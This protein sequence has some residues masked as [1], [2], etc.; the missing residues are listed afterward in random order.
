MVTGINYNRELS[1]YKTL[2]QDSKSFSDKF[3]NGGSQLSTTK[4]FKRKAKW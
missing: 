2:P 4:D 1:T 3:G